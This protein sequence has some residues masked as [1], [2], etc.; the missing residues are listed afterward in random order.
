MKE[1]AKGARGPIRVKSFFQFW[2]WIQGPFI[3]IVEMLTMFSI[4]CLVYIRIESFIKRK[5]RKKKVKKKIRKGVNKRS[6]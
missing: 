5:Q 6:R 3:L 2:T 4:A 1:I